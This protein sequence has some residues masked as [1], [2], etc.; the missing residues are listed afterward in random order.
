MKLSTKEKFFRIIDAMLYGDAT[1]KKYLYGI[2]AFTIITSVTGVMAIFGAGMVYGLVSMLAGVVDLIWWQSMTLTADDLKEQGNK[3]RYLHDKQTKKLEKE[4]EKAEEKARKEE[5][6]RKNKEPKSEM[7]KALGKAEES[8]KKNAEY[9]ISKEEIKYALKKY[10]AKKD[11]REVI[12]D[13]CASLGLREAPAYI[14]AD[15]KK[16]Y[17]MILTEGEPLKID[18]PLEYNLKL[19]YEKGV[20]SNPDTEYSKFKGISI[21]S[22]AFSPFLPDYYQKRTDAGTAFYK[23]L[24]RLG[25]DMYFTNTSAKNVFDMTGADFEVKDDIT[26]D[27]RHGE[28]FKNAYKANLLWRDGAISSDEYKNMITGLLSSLARADI[29]LD[30][31]NRI[32]EQMYEYNFI[33]KSYMYFYLDY[34]KKYRET[35]KKIKN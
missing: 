24:Y 13:S 27:V 33:T 26:E 12:I 8:F 9:K 2:A 14:W 25:K 17:F 20:K 10:K 21:V 6:K 1:T 30:D 34:R 18:Y 5:E 15:K 7:E 35:K 4:K 31:F 19:Y 16:Y 22:M 32:L 11:H 23:N 29:R 3:D 28:D